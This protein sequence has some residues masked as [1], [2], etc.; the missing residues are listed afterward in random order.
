MLAR[1]YCIACYITPSRSARVS[2]F[3]R[4]SDPSPHESLPSPVSPAVSTRTRGRSLAV[5][6]STHG[7]RSVRADDPREVGDQLRLRLRIPCGIPRLLLPHGE[8]VAR[9]ERG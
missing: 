6:C 9:R 2:P 8:V 7:V 1:A 3:G 4:Q 5:P